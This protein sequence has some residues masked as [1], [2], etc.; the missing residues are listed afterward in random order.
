[1][2]VDLWDLS[3]GRL[4]CNLSGGLVDDAFSPDG[5][6]LFSSNVELGPP[7]RYVPLEARVWDTKSG[8]KLATLMIKT[9]GAG[10]GAFSPDNRL[11]LTVPKIGLGRLCISTRQRNWSSSLRREHGTDDSRIPHL[12]MKPATIGG[13]P[14]AGLDAS[15]KV[16]WRARIRDISN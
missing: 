8:E 12:R 16:Q 11:P 3:T 5:S 1:M 7:Y 2:D 4:V 15:G 6:R 9:G 10:G 14:S 13:S